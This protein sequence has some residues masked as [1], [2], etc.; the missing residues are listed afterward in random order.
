MLQSLYGQLFGVLLVTLISFWTNLSYG[1]GRSIPFF[2]VATKVQSSEN[3]A[4]KKT[5]RGRVD[6][7]VVNLSDVDQKVTVDITAETAAVTLFI[8]NPTGLSNWTES[9]VQNDPNSETIAQTI[10]L[11][12]KFHPAQTVTL[13]GHEEKIVYFFLECTANFNGA[14]CDSKFTAGSCGNSD[15]AQIGKEPNGNCLYP[16]DYTGT[17]GA[18]TETFEY[19]S[20]ANVAIEQDTGAVISSMKVES[21]I[22]GGETGSSQVQNFTLNGGRPF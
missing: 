3:V 2:T 1:T 13:K 22:C 19:K 17:N 8:R 9:F 10:N 5:F 15:F 6:V 16:K 21:Y 14:H 12:D 11:G 18:C 7:S 20:R 4:T